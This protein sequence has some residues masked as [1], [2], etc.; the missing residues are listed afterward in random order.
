MGGSTIM[1][2]FAPIAILGLLS[3]TAQ[4]QAQPCLNNNTETVALLAHGSI[5]AGFVMV[6]SDQTNLFV[7]FSTIPD[8]KISRLDLAVAT[9]LAG[10]PQS[11]GQPDL[12]SFPY[13]KS[14][15][16]DV[17]T[18]TF[19]IPLGATVINSMPTLFIAAHAA[20]DSATQ[21][22]QQAWGAGQLF[23]C[24]MACKTSSGCDDD[25]DHGDG[26]IGI[27]GTSNDGGGHGGD[28][29]EHGD[30]QRGVG[31]S[32]DGGG[33]KCGCSH[34]DEKRAQKRA[35]LQSSSACG[36]GGDDHGDARGGASLQWGS[37]GGEGDS[38]GGD[39]H[40]GDSQGVS[41]QNGGGDD[42]HKN[43]DG[44]SDCKAG[45]GAT[46]FVYMV[47]CVFAHE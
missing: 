28:D 20:L 12:S 4:A 46:Y 5:P 15:S 44:G 9:S 47:N 34:G 41:L 1:R 27:I 11:G 3:W 7:Q 35:A 31:T 23:P 39:E 14:F 18:Y 40:H 45:C 36:G 2:K 10:I 6:S 22:H 16:P 19:T 37:G 32:D 24:S 29:C 42:Q 33:N 43:D 30:G 17:T 26:L 13:R 25:G 21:G 38:C 8:W